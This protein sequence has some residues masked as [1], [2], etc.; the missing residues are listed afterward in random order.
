M[1]DINTILSNNPS[2]PDSGSLFDVNEIDN[3]TGT[4]LT[5]KAALEELSSQKPTT[6]HIAILEEA[7]RTG[8][9]Y[10]G[11]TA[12]ASNGFRFETLKFATNGSTSQTLMMPAA[13]THPDQA[14]HDSL[15][16]L[17]QG[18]L[19]YMV[20][21]HLIWNDIR[22]DEFLSYSKDL[23]FLVVHALDRYHDFQ[24]NVTIQLFDRRKAV[25]V[26]GEPA[27]FYPALKVYEA[28]K[29][30][31]W[32]G[33]TD[34]NQIQLHSRI[35]TQE[36]LS[37]GTILVKDTRFQQVPI[38]TLIRDGLYDIFPAFQVPDDHLRAGLYTG[39]VVFRKAGYP[40]GEPVRSL[41]YPRIYSYKRCAREVPFTTQ[42]LKKVQKLTGNFTT[43]K[44][45]N[46]SATCEPHLHIF[47][48]FLTF[49]KRPKRDAVFLGWIQT[50]YSGMCFQHNG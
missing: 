43:L 4:A 6:E 39:Q 49:E 18:E 48:S 47:L 32:T 17:T 3:I 20:G 14:L 7:K 22:G 36:Y 31:S 27:A 44:D 46:D 38:E 40:P 13:D 35:F 15:Y 12:S 23:L 25:N 33:W 8:P 34:Y 5:Y 29:V 24:S 26:K 28:F 2:R 50:H 16:D 30:P 9:N 45:F 11:R 10:L 21:Q 19:V 1:N 42:L 37:H 41:R